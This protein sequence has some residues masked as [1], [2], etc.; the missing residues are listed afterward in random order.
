MMNIPK[1][2]F[3]F[4]GFACFNYKD[5]LNQIISVIGILLL[6]VQFVEILRCPLTENTSNKLILPN[7][8]I[9]VIIIFINIYGF[10]NKRN[11]L[12]L[13]EINR[14]LVEVNDKV[15]CF[16]HDFNNILQAIHG[17]IMLEDMASLQTYFN[18]LVKESNYVNMV[19][20]LNNR[21]KE[22]PAISSVLLSK[23]KLAE[24]NNIKMNIE[25]SIDLSKFKRNS[26]TI[27]RMLGIL[28]D[29]A[30]EASLETE[31]KIV[32]VQFLKDESKNRDLIKIENTYINKEVDI[33]KIFE[34]EYTTK[35]GNTGLGLWKIKD[36]LS[37]DDNFDLFT[38]KD[39]YMF[40]QQLEIYR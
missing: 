5:V 28:L 33:R 32:N 20:F 23:F 40:K 11:F 36:I 4:K 27:S 18:S 25:I 12:K 37:K 6:I 2:Y 21:V 24:K 30:L 7:I 15:R 22:N 16:K 13:Q 19:D 14:N 39:D 1:C 38:T 31:E 8:L 10:I 17:Y 26:Y 9:F 3:K 29:N 35:V 34:K